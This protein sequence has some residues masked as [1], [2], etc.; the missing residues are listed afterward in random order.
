MWSFFAWILAGCETQK[1]EG[2][3]QGQYA[4]DNAGFCS[5]YRHKQ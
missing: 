2:S 4:E 3:V 5:F 1:E